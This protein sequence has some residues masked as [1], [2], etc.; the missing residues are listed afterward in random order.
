MEV[1]DIVTEPNGAGVK[2][3]NGYLYQALPDGLK[4]YPLE[5]IKEQA[6]AN[7]KQSAL[8]E[9][10]LGD[11]HTGLSYLKQF[12]FGSG[13]DAVVEVACSPDIKEATFALTMTQGK[14]N[15]R[16]ATQKQ[17]NKEV[18]FKWRLMQMYPWV[19]YLHSLDPGMVIQCTQNEDSHGLRAKAEGKQYLLLMANEE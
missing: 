6:S 12:I 14:A 4:N 5:A 8:V 1:T 17:P 9:F 11:L 18:T 2:F 15:R 10:E 3:D 13:D 19:D 7:L 16:V